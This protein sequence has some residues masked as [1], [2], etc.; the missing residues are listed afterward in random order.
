MTG[1]FM[2]Y[3]HAASKRDPDNCSACALEHPIMIDYGN[4]VERMGINYAAWPLSYMANGRRIPQ[5][6][7]KYLLEELESD[8]LA[9]VENLKT[10]LTKH[11]YDIEV[12][13]R[14]MS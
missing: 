6:F 11:G 2:H 13:K 5:R 1:E 14:R 9:Y 4:G 8:N 3:P 10:H 12:I 7:M